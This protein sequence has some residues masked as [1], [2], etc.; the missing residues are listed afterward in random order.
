[1]SEIVL[2]PVPQ[3]S[4]RPFPQTVH[5]VLEAA[6]NLALISRTNTK[7]AEQ[8]LHGERQQTSSYR[9]ADNPGENRDT[10]IH[11]RFSSQV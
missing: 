7:R 6:R 11:P 3:A 8:A 5:E 9:Y 2:A 1:M 4:L 10:H